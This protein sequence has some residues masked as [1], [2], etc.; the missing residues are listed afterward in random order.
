MGI[1]DTEDVGGDDF[2]FALGFGEFHFGELFGPT[3]MGVFHQDLMGFADLG[4]EVFLDLGVTS[5]AQSGG[6]LLNGVAVDLFGDLG[7]RRAL[8]F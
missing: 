4:G 5:C 6:A 3:H 1:V 2:A 8:S 7:R